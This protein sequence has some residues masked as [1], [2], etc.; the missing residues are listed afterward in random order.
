MRLDPTSWGRRSTR[1]RAKNWNF[2]IL[3]NGMCTNQNQS[4]RMRCMKFSGISRNKGNTWSQSG[5]IWFL[6]FNGISTFVGYLMPKSPFEKNS[7]G[8]IYPI[9][10]G[11][12]S[13][14]KGICPKINVIAR[15]EFELTY[16]DSAIY[17]FNPI[18][19]RIR[20]PSQKS[21]HSDII[22]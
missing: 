5:F 1:N 10:M 2:T 4:K 12:H 20:D 18:T 22:F 19:T 6:C 9:A 11:F 3:S 13:I 14:P 17:R 7:S 8:N 15:L 16:Y 21:R